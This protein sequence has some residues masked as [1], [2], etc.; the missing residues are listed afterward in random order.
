MSGPA[1]YEA[2]AAR[3]RA[4]ALSEHDP[5]ARSNFEALA[6]G[7]LRLG[8]QTEPT[9]TVPAANG[10]VAHGNTQQTS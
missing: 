4:R 10:P 9:D 2:M 7:Y 6:S 8:T 3:F 5:V 1:F